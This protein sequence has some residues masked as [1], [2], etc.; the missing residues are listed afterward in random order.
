MEHEIRDFC[1]S[2]SSDVAA[3]CSREIQIIL[4]IENLPVR[5]FKGILEVCSRTI[6]IARLSNILVLYS[7]VR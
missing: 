4:K 7:F 5:Y 6:L 2:G 1:K 3:V